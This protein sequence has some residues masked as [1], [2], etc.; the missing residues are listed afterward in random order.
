VAAAWR[1][2][3]ALGARSLTQHIAPIADALARGDLPPRAR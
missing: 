3:C 2:Y 1:P